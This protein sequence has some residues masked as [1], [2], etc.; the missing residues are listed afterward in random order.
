MSN[1]ASRALAEASLPG[2]PRTY[3]TTFKRSGVP[4]A[5]FI[6]AIMD[7]HREKKRHKANSI[8]LRQRK[9]PSKSI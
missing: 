7:G 3:D 9:M 5:T 2:E 4:L 8:L 6:I 1:R